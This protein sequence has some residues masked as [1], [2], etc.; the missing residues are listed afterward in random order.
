MMVPSQISENCQDFETQRLE[1]E[2]LNSALN[3]ELEQNRSNLSEASRKEYAQQAIIKKL[4]LKNTRLLG[5]IKERDEKIS[6]QEQEL[7]RYQGLVE[8]YTKNIGL[9]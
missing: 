2:S 9:Q 4:T 1:H 6:S 3:E 7:V 5:R 8:N